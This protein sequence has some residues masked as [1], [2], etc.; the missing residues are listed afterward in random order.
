MNSAAPRRTFLA[1]ALVSGAA[2][3]VGVSTMIQSGEAAPQAAAPRQ[4]YELGIYQLTAGMQSRADECFEHAMLP[5]AARAGAGPIGVFVDSTKAD[6]PVMYVLIPH[7]GREA[8]GALMK[9]L[10]DDAEYQKAG[11]P[12]IAASAKD[13]SYSN[14]EVRLMLAAAFMPALDA[15]EK[16]ETRVFELRRYRSPSEAAFRKKLEMFAT[17][18]LAIFRRVGLNPVFFGEMLFGPDMPNITYM[19]TYPDAAARGKAWAEFGKNPD[20]QKLRVTPGYTDAEIISNISSI[21]L[22]PASYSQI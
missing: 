3:A 9:A 14:H 11:K 6:S 21:M 5:A 12:F 1:Q 15:P 13:P 2:G 4:F 19:L 7:V 17:S 18:E 10:H 16:K 8:V 22:K 20:W